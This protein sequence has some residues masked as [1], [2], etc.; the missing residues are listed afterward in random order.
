MSRAITVGG[1]FGKTG[2]GGMT[3]MM[4][5]KME[6]AHHKAK[7]ATKKAELDHL[8]NRVKAG[9]FVKIEVAVPTVRHEDEDFIDY[10]ARLRENEERQDYVIETARNAAFLR[11]SDGSINVVKFFRNDCVCGVWVWITPAIGQVKKAA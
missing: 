3:T 5:S 9:E 7:L 2:K 4:L 6:I 8:Y 10:E 1:A 11:K